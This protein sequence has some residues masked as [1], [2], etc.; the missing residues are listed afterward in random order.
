ML[1]L[2]RHN[3]LKIDKKKFL[4]NDLLYSLILNLSGFNFNFTTFFMHRII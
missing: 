1:K 4:K 3:I 2:K